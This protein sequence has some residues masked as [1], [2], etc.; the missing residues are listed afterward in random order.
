MNE[1]LEPEDLPEVGR[2]KAGLHG[3]GLA[4]PPLVPLALVVGILAG[5]AA[6]IGL[7]PA[8]APPVSP[9][10]SPTPTPGITAPVAIWTAGDLI[11]IPGRVRGLVA[12]TPPSGGLSLEEALDRLYQ[13]DPTV[14]PGQVVSAV[15]AMAEDADGQQRWAWVFTVDRTEV[16]CTD[17]SSDGSA[18]STSVHY[19]YVAGG[20]MTTTAQ[21]AECQ[22]VMLSGDI[23]L[24][25]WTGEQMATATTWNTTIT[26]E[27][28]VSPT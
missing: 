12:A 9:T 23:A 21:F 10:S 20:S 8:A 16:L 11:T 27:P 3:H 1:W 14:T 26:G 7:A 15:V 13:L 25:Y 19:V 2:V 18:V 4:L 22:V 17:R 24:N 28:L 6:G 5:L